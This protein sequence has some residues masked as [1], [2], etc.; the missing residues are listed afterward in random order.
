MAVDLDRLRRITHTFA[1]VP[2]LSLTQSRSPPIPTH[3]YRIPFDSIRFDWFLSCPLHVSCWS[4]HPVKALVCIPSPSRLSNTIHPSLPRSH[5]AMCVL[6]SLESSR[7]H[8]LCPVDPSCLL[9]C[10][11]HL[12]VATRVVPWITVPFSCAHARGCTATVVLRQWH[13]NL[14]KEYSHVYPCRTRRFRFHWKSPRSLHG[15]W[16]STS[17]SAS[18]TAWHPIVSLQ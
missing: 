18:G 5:S 1:V 11:I 4:V 17:D 8:C 7:F 12:T 6:H 13:G 14:Y 15:Y 3:M 9:V 10:S 2:S 16:T